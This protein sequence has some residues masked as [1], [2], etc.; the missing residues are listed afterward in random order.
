[1]SSACMA[2]TAVFQYMADTAGHANFAD[3]RQYDIF[4]ANARRQAAV[5][6][7]F[8]GLGTVH[9]QTLCRQDM[10]NITGADTKAKQPK[11]PC[12]L[13]CESPQTTVIPGKV[14]PCSG[15]MICTI[16]C[17]ISFMPISRI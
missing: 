12:V 14:I 4:R 2:F 9:R 13:V 8:H 15:P 11:A 7:N 10:L 16:P 5:D 1:M 17:L 6:L 3:N